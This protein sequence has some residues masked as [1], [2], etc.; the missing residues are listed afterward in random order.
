MKAY[1]SFDGVVFVWYDNLLD[2]DNSDVY[3]R[4][5]DIKIKGKNDTQS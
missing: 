5:L 1:P 4:H 2:C 3:N